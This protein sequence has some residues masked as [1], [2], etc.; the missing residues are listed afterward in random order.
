M[1]RWSR[2]AAVSARRRQ[3]RAAAP[4]RPRGSGPAAALRTF[5]QTRDPPARD[6]LV[7]LYLP[8]VIA[9]AR[10][11][12]H[13]GEPLEDLVQVG[14]IGLIQ[15]IDRFDP[16]RG[17]AALRR[18]R[19]RRSRARSAAS[20]ATAA[21]RS[22]CRAAFRRRARGFCGAATSSRRGSGDA[23]T[24]ERARSRERAAAS[25]SPRPRQPDARRRPRR[26]PDGSEPA[27]R[28]RST[29]ARRE[30]GP[31][32]ARGRLRRAGRPRAKGPA[33]ALLRRAQPD[34]DRRRRSASR[35]P[36][37]RGSSATPWPSCATSSTSRN[38]RPSGP[39]RYHRPTGRY[40]RPADAKAPAG[41]WPRRRPRYHRSHGDPAARSLDEY[42]DLPYHLAISR[43][44]D[45]DR[46]RGVGRA[47]RG[48]RR[49]RGAGRTPRRR[50]GR[51]R[52]ALEALD[53]ACAR[54]RA[55]VPLPRSP[56]RT[57]AACCCAWPRRCTPSS[58]APPSARTSAST[59]SSAAPRGR[60]RRWR[61]GDR[62]GPGPAGAPPGR[63]RTWSSG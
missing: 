57:A 30:R 3:E 13:C 56:R 28:G 45:A 37:S 9:I 11:Y 43:D 22:G 32:A 41:V 61:R 12:E 33:P 51:V 25:P 60:R 24:S 15:A 50:R 40:H 34:A 19:S 52:E 20:C 6:E 27:Q 62:R 17:V 63:E 58:R 8:L 35:R 55:H 10:R 21:A 7:E 18:S 59:S 23:P 5:L 42:L 36:T 44:E 53:R 38:R 31:R 26:S 16:A 2:S 39:R 1:T 49:L 29:A 48:A 14:A 54:T 47:R 4:D 46:R